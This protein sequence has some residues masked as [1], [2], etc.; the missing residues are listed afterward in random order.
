MYPGKFK[1]P[2]P[3]VGEPVPY[4][5]V[6]H[7]QAAPGRRGRHLTAAIGLRYDAISANFHVGVA[8]AMQV[9]RNAKRVFRFWHTISAMAG[10]LGFRS[11]RREGRYH[12]RSGAQH[13]TSKRCSSG[14]RHESGKPA[15]I[16]SGNRARTRR[17]VEVDAQESLGSTFL[18]HL[19]PFLANQWRLP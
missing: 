5:R 15:S 8:V 4:P 14:G 9:S 12:G 11:L 6:T 2:N 19:T 18:S 7:R 3:S 16:R 13:R 1:R 10:G 17:A